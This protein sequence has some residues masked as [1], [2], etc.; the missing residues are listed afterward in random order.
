MH[1]RDGLIEVPGAKAEVVK[2]VATIVDHVA[3]Y[4]RRVIGRL[5]QLVGHV[6]GE[7]KRDVQSGPRWLAPVERALRANVAEGPPWTDL[8]TRG[9][10]LDGGVEILHDKRSLEYALGRPAP[11]GGHGRIELPAGET[12]HVRE[13]PRS[14]NSPLRA[15]R[16]ADGE[17]I[18]VRCSRRRPQGHAP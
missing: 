6:P 12:A 1:R 3:V 8:E 7:S 13:H 4:R 11:V 9:E 10:L 2:T 15:A 18:I 14:I 16:F 17:T 5:D